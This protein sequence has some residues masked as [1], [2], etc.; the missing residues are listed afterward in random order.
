MVTLRELRQKAGLSQEQCARA[1][2]ISRPAWTH[3]ETGRRRPRLENALKVAQLFGV[4]VEAIFGRRNG[5]PA[6]GCNESGDGVATP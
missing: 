3:Y 2:G 1:I 4:P 6:E 5:E